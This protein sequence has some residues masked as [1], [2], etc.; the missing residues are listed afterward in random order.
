LVAPHFQHE[1][2]WGSEVSSQAG[3]TCGY[4]IAHQA[5]DA[6]AFQHMPKL[7]NLAGIRRARDSL[8]NACWL[9]NPTSH[10]FRRV[11]GLR[12]EAESRLRSMFMHEVNQFLEQDEV[13]WNRADAR[14]NHDA[15][16][17]V[18]LSVSF[19]DRGIETPEQ[20][21]ASMTKSAHRLFANWQS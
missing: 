4:F 21:S 2:N 8:Y 7:C 11:S 9:L 13:S 16:F 6:S 15:V 1:V 14:A 17:D 20:S 10:R 3:H 18:C 19:W 12:V 5:S